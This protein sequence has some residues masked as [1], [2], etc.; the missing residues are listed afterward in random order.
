MPKEQ[1]KRGTILTCPKCGEDITIMSEKVTMAA[2]TEYN[3]PLKAVSP[4]IGGPRPDAIKRALKRLR[5]QFD[6][7]IPDKRENNGKDS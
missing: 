3:G 7:G 5:K 1:R 6:Y 2:Q 4:K